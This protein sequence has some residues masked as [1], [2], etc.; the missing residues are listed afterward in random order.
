M[1][2]VI[3]RNENN[4]HLATHT[5]F[6]SIESAQAYV[7]G[8]N[9]A[10]VPMIVEYDGKPFRDDA[11]ERGFVR[12]AATP[13]TCGYCGHVGPPGTAYDGWRCCEACQGC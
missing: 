13:F 8:I 6:P 9:P 3:S 10:R 11:A 5:L 1:F 2:I 12:L 7:A 4:Y